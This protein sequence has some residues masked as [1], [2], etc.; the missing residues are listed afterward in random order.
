MTPL[1]ILDDQ[2]SMNGSIVSF[3]ERHHNTINYHP[4]KKESKVVVFFLLSLPF[5]TNHKNTV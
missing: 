4:D 1:L 5:S 3:H 2:S